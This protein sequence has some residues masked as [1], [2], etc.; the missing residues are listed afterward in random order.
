MRGGWNGLFG[1][2]LWRFDRGGLLHGSAVMEKARTK[3]NCSE[4]EGGHDREREVVEFGQGWQQGRPLKL[5]LH[6]VVVRPAGGASHRDGLR[7]DLRL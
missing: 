5:R 3:E 1:G 4:C 7:I 2:G 6:E